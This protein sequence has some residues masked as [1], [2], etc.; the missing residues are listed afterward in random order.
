M[1]TLFLAT[2]VALMTAAYPTEQPAAGTYG[3]SIIIQDDITLIVDT[4]DP[5]VDVVDIQ[6]YGETA[7]SACGQ[8]VCNANISYLDPGFYLVVV[9]TSEGWF[10]SDDILVVN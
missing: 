8:P 7:P 4:E 3:G 5:N 2:L 1:K 9:E 6:I 10:F